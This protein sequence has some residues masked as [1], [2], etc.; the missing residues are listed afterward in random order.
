MIEVEVRSFVS[1]EQFSELQEFMKQNTRYLGHD[2][3][4]TY[5]FSGPVDLRIQRGNDYAKLW[6]KSGKL[7]D[8]YREEIEVKFARDDFE[9]L[10]SLLKALGH[11][12]EIKWFR[13]RDRF[14]WD[15][16]KVTL[17]CTKDYGYI[18]ELEKLTDKDEEKEKIHRELEEKLKSLGVKPTPKEVFDQKFVQ[19]KQNWKELKA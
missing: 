12:V 5:Y 3:Q 6:L 16:I 8:K 2:S 14:S 15:G 10:E 19:Y 17:D 1:E 9:K 7:H 4:T 18:I 11:E 13:E